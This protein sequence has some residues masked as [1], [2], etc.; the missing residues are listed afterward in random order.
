VRA[1]AYGKL[2]A[3]V[4]SS[5]F[6][7]LLLDADAFV[8]TGAWLAASV[9]VDQPAAAYGAEVLKGRRRKLL[10]AARDLAHADDEAR[11]HTRIQAKKLRYTFEAFRPLYDEKAGAKFMD[12][13][14]DLQ[15]TL[16]D[17][18]DLAV[19]AALSTDLKLKG[20]ALFAA[21]QVIGYGQAA[22]PK[23]IKQAGKQAKALS[24][25]DAPWR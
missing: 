11:H 25:I 24:E 1:A 20:P 2:A 23:L 13:L 17:L 16:G 7:S 18:N 15:A 4:G 10:K 22:R 6:R 8:E 19:A 14:K 9:L 21:G 5:R 12:A 3:A